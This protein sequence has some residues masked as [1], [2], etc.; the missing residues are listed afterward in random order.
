MMINDDDEKRVELLFNY[1][2][3]YDSRF[4]LMNQFFAHDT[5][6]KKFNT[7]SRVFFIFSYREL[8]Y[9]H[10]ILKA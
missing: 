7:M 6:G 9:F 1:D 10:Y 3:N 8:S 5:K 4:A 2:S